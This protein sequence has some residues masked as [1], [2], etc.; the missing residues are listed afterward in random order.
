MLKFSFALEVHRLTRSGV[1]YVEA[2]GVEAQS[3]A[4]LAVGG[5]ACAV[6]VVTRDRRIQSLAV[7]CVESQLMGASSDGV[8]AHAGLRALHLDYLIFGYGALAIVGYHLAW[9]VVVVEF[10]RQRDCTLG[11]RYHAI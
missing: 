2:F 7:G 10:H 4:I 8:E 6:D 9:T 1:G 11:L 3:F 5:V